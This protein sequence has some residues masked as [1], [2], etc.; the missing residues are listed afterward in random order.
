MINPLRAIYAGLMLIWIT[1]ALLVISNAIEVPGSF[2]DQKLW[3]KLFIVAVLTFNALLLHGI[4]SPTVK[5]RISHSLF[6]TVLNQLPVASILFGAVVAV[7]CLFAAYLGIAKKLHAEIDIVSASSSYV[8]A[9]LLTWLVGI[10]LC[11]VVSYCKMHLE[12][13]KDFAI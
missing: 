3:A 2:A 9:L 1:G 10:T 12:F 5:S 6:G 4:I 13:R 8:I 7:S 11:V